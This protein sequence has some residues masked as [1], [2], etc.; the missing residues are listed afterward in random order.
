[1]KLFSRSMLVLLAVAASA[2]CEQGRERPMY[3]VAG[4]DPAR[5]PALIRQYGCHGCHLVPGVPGADGMVGPPLIH[6]SRR[7]F[8]AGRLPNNPDNLIVWMMNPQ[9]VNPGS[10]MPDSGL[11]EADAR[12]I[13]AYLFT[14]N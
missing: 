9:A 2:A 12:D 5:A 8:I 14:L 4:G 7:T 10:A 1:M 13:A 6:W 11:T 3:L